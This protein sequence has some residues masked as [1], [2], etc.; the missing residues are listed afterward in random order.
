[1]YENLTLWWNTLN[2]LQRVFYYCA[3]PATVILIIQTILNI[4]AIG[5]HDMDLHNH[6]GI[7]SVDLDGDFDIGGD[8]IADVEP[9]HGLS[10]LRFFSIRGLVA[11]FSIFGWVGASLAKDD[12]INAFVIFFIASACGFL[13]MAV[14]AWLFYAINKLQVSG[15]TNYNNAIG[16]IGEVYLTIPPARTGYGKVNVI[17]QD[18][19]SEIQAMSDSLEPLTTGMSVHVIGVVNVNTLLVEKQIK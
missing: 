2:T 18:R 5:N 10:G 8:T 15:N 7:G 14:I 6:G 17:V 19:L 13:G 3:I 11:F 16:S 12:N 1:M 9:I 4:F